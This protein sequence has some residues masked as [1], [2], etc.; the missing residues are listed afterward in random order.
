MQL[1]G[2]GGEKVRG[3]LLF[4]DLLWMMLMNTN[5]QFKIDQRVFSSFSKRKPELNNAQSHFQKQNIE[6]T[7]RFAIQHLVLFLIRLK[8]FQARLEIVTESSFRIC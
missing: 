8:H 5:R 2:S 7:S 3:L 4:C 1:F 6:I